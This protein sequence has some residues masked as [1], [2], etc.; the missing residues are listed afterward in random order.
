MTA[1]IAAK[2]F[3]YTDYP[4][5][6]C[7]FETFCPSDLT[8]EVLE[9]A[10]AW[11]AIAEALP[12]SYSE[13]VQRIWQRWSRNREELEPLYRRLPTSV[14]QA[15][16]NPTNLLIDEDGKFKGVFDFNLAGKDVFLNYLMRENDTE[17]IPEALTIARE[18]YVFSEEEKEAALPLFRCLKPLWW[19]SLQA[20]KDA[21]SDEE[22]VR[23]ALDKSEA[24]LTEEKDFRSYM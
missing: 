10:L 21:G 3:D 22:A 18:H 16:L 12:D 5:A 13:Q 6:Y 4:S 8:D 19:N 15:D 24:C 23:Q 20:L 7:L 9:N 17:T 2:R 11:K 14:F 1:R